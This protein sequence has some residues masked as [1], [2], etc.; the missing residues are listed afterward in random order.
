MSCTATVVAAIIVAGLLTVPVL[1][2]ILE[3]P[4]ALQTG[5]PNPMVSSSV[6]QDFAMLVNCVQCTW[7]ADTAH[8]SMAGRCLARTTTPRARHRLLTSRASNQ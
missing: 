1:N 4:V 5:R 7:G 2:S 6:E 8:T 3:G